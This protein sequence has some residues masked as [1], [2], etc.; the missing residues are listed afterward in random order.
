MWPGEN[1]DGQ[2]KNHTKL[3]RYRSEILY[4]I[5]SLF[6]QI[7][8]YMFVFVLVMKTENLMH[9]RGFEHTLLAIQGL[10]R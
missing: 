8:T 10:V 4:L 6:I 5:L 1:S 3:P 2:V 9:R 7:H